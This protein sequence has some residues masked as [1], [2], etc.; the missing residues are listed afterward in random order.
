MIFR[1]KG[2]KDIMGEITIKEPKLDYKKLVF[3]KKSE[4]GKLMTKRQF[5]ECNRTIHVAAVAAGASGAIPLPGVD[6]IPISA[7]QVTMIVSLGKIFDH[8]LSESA[9]KG[10]I[11]AATSTFVGRNLVKSIP[12]AGWIASAGVA[13]GVTEFIGWTVAVDFAKQN[14]GNVISDDNDDFAA[15]PMDDAEVQ[16]DESTD[17]SVVDDITRTLGEEEDI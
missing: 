17:D 5:A 11:G 12:I 2:W 16:N 15:T 9:I 8:K 13:A 4:A 10:I 14:K 1:N 6:A 7:A 3:E